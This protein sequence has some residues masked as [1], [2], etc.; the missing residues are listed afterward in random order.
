MKIKY[1]TLW[2]TVL[3]LS[4]GAGWADD[5]PR[6]LNYQGKLADDMGVPLNLETEMTFAIYTAAS[7]GGVIWS[8]TQTVLITDGL[9]NVLLGTV[10]PLEPD[11][12][13]ANP[14]TYFG[15][16]VSDDPEM[17]PRQEIAGAVY[18]LKTAGFGVKDEKVGVGTAVPEAELDVDGYVKSEI[19]AFFVRNSGHR[20]AP[21]YVT[22]DAVYHNTEGGYDAGTGRFTAPVDGLYHFAWGGINNPA[23]TLSRSYLHINGSNYAAEGSQLRLDSGADYGEGSNY[24]TIPL[25]QGDWVAIYLGVGGLHTTYGYFTGYLVAA[26]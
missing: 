11:Y 9:F 20:A 21:E 12:F 14:V 17:A 15:V 5:L 10:N 24:A 22:W 1:L 18:S 6:L 26:Q 3:L 23:G 25:S 16:R 2:L 7:G 8:E 19:P 4:T 13:S